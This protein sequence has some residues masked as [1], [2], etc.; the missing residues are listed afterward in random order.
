MLFQ[1]S[2]GM[3]GY[4]LLG[5]LCLILS[6]IAATAHWFPR[7]SAML[8]VTI[9]VAC[10][11]WRLRIHEG[12][13]WEW[14]ALATGAFLAVLFA[15]G[16]LLL[17]AVRP[18]EG[19][20]LLLQWIALSIPVVAFEAYLIRLARNSR[21]RSIGDHS[22]KLIALSA[23]AVLLSSIASLQGSWSDHCFYG[24]A[25]VPL[26]AAM[27]IV[28]SQN[29]HARERNSVPT[30]GNELSHTSRLA[31]V[32]ELTASIAH[33]IN[34]P[35]SAILSNADAGDILLENSDA[36]MDEIRKILWDIR[37]DG[38]RASDVIRNVRTLAQKREPDLIK[39][40]L[41]AVVESVVEL[42][43]Q[44][45]RRRGVGILV[46]PFWKSAYV[47]GDQTLLVQVLINLIM[48]AMD[49]LEAS[50]N[51]ADASPQ[52]PP[53]ELKVSVSLYDEIQIRVVDQGAG[54]P[55]EQL[56][57][58]FDSFYT[59]KSHGMGLGLSIS[60]SIISAHGGRIFANNNPGPGATFNIFLPPYSEL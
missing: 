58:L 12:L 1:G 8:V 29:D 46:T 26:L 32:G 34:Q 27:L 50:R 5:I 45:M 41:N 36:P 28:E 42:L 56:D 23:I 10:M 16:L 3:R 6:A 51:R 2:G 57:Q 30:P 43:D 39:L 21:R 11:V 35:L 19:G 49:S 40:D 4:P 53:I 25:L 24:A 52:P 9:L 14:L 54:I 31:V 15:C 59:S 47:R 22:R 37:R 48:N 17:W 20:L 38:L 7:G 55:K 44:E 13:R 33:E 60:R 18:R